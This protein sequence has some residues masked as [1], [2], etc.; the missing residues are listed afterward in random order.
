M[1][2]GLGGIFGDQHA[3]GVQDKD[4]VGRGGADGEGKIGE[5]VGFPGIGEA[6]AWREKGAGEGRAAIGS[7]REEV[8]PGTDLAEGGGRR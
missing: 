3:A 5:G 4:R 6:A 7:H 2:D 8:F 1:L